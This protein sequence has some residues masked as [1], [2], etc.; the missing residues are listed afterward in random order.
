MGASIV[1]KPDSNKWVFTGE[2]QAESVAKA[3]DGFIAGFVLCPTCQDPGT[4]LLPNEKQE[5]T[6]DC[7]ACGTVSR[8]TANP[9]FASF[10]L[11]HPLMKA[12]SGD[13]MPPEWMEEKPL[14]DQDKDFEAE[15]TVEEKEEDPVDALARFFAL[16]PRPPS[17]EIKAR[18]EEL[19]NKHGWKRAD[20]IKA[21]FG[22]LFGNG[23]FA[24]RFKLDAPVL[25]LFVTTSKDQARLLML[26]EKLCSID[27][28][29]LAKT[30]TVLQQWYEKDVLDEKVIKKW[31][32]AAVEADGTTTSA[33]RQK[34]TRFI[35]WL[36]NAESDDDD[37]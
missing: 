12:K 31:Y 18:V 36:S 3:L 9:R 16:S 23:R 15:W 25:R 5:L 34:A 1:H 7:K 17:S 11:K 19:S 14:T 22:A 35:E 8:V 33:V 32:D 10:V 30:C 6:L 21:V 24:E 13:Y 4:L 20:A 29:A 28:T 27:P 26:F 37:A 2:H